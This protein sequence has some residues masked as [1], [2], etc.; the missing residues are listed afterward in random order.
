MRL[1][2]F[3]GSTFR[4]YLGGRIIVTSPERAPADVDRAELVAAAD[5]LIDLGDGVS[6]YPVID[7]ETWQPRRPE[8]L[9]EQSGETIVELFALAGEGL[10]VDEAEE[11][12]VIIAPAGLSEWGRFADDAVVV[13][14]GAPQAVTRTVNV[15]AMAARP[16]LIALAAEGLTD[17]QF[18]TTASAAGASPVQVLER[19]LA[20]EA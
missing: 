4:L 10:I 14:Y 5:H 1:T 13:V 6:E 7:P 20:L 15:L 11:G 8:R 17:D 9:V 19:G 18:T 2:W 12:P 3:G 16:K